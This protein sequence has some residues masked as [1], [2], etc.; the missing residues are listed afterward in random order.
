MTKK[1]QQNSK[2]R[3]NLKTN[4]GSD[5]YTTVVE[6]EL[7]I[8]TTFFS[9]MHCYKYMTYQYLVSEKRDRNQHLLVLIIPLI[10]KVL[11]S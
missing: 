1:V 6:M 8:H 9:K 7:D 11:Y 3:H 4:L 5:I 10:A 2:I